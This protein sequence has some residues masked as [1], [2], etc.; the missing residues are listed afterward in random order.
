[1]RREV[2][3]NIDSPADIV[4]ARQQARELATQHSTFPFSASSSF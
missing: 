3:V 1:M 4:V 2:R